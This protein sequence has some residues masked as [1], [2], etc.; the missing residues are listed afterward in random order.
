MIGPRRDRTK[1]DREAGD[2]MAMRESL[3][4]LLATGGWPRPD[5]DAYGPGPG[6]ARLRPRP[7]LAVQ[8]PIHPLCRPDRP[9]RSP[10][11]RE[12]DDH[13]AAQRPPRRQSVRGVHGGTPRRT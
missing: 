9:G 1:F 13:P 6:P 5:A 4:R 10:G 3:A 2:E 12:A 7:V 11:R 8:L